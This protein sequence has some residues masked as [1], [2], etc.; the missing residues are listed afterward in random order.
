VGS[1][2]ELTREEWD[3]WHDERRW[4]WLADVTARLGRAASVRLE[5]RRAVFTIEGTDFALVPGG[6]VRL[7]FDPGAFVPSDGQRA[8]Y[9]ESVEA[10][11]MPPALEEH[12]AAVLS[13]PREV[14]PPA[15][16]VEAVAA[17]VGLQPLPADD[18]DVKDVVRSMRKDD[19][20]R[21]IAGR[22]RH[23]LRVQRSEGVLRAWTVQPTSRPDL[24]RGLASRGM[25]LLTSDEWEHACGGAAPTL[26][27]WGDDCP[28]DRTPH[29][30]TANECR[31]REALVRLL[32][33]DEPDWDQHLRPNVFGLTIARDPYANE[34]VAE[35]QLWRGG[36]GGSSMCGGMGYFLCWL[37][38]ATSYLHHEMMAAADNGPSSDVHG[39]WMRRVLPLP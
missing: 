26:F 10:W 29:D 36:D 17:E 25:R 4:R 35:P 3:G 30:N 15:L 18:P 21:I 2:A 39:W 31:R 9:E 22:G 6:R 11:G 5:G 34:L 14:R 23:E 27:R 12:L 38:L 13:P 8:S 20:I 16:L 28:C 33:R 7:G 19:R 1:A 37:P 32:V 24:E